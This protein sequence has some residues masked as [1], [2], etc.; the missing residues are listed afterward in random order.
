PGGLVAAQP[1]HA[2]QAQGAEALL[3]IGQVPR[4]RQPHAQGRARLVEDGAGGDAALVA[5]TATHQPQPTGSI[6]RLH[7]ATARADESLR[8]AQPLQIGQARPL[9]GEPVQKFVPVAGVV[10]A[11]LRRYAMLG[12]HPVVPALLELKGYPLYSYSP[13]SRAL[14]RANALDAARPQARDPRRRRQV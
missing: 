12:I 8:P 6:G 13:L 7:H 2:L 3:L 9:T 10:L 1:Q 5:A 4:R 11:S 14:L